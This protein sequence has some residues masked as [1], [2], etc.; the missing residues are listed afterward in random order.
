MA[1]DHFP[2]DDEN[3]QDSHAASVGERQEGGDPRFKSGSREVSSPAS[4]APLPHV[5]PSIGRVISAVAV[6]FVLIVGAYFFRHTHQGVSEA[7]LEQLTREFPPAIARVLAEKRQ[8]SHLNKL[9]ITKKE[10]DPAG[11]VHFTY[12]LSFDETTPA[13]ESTTNTLNQ[14]AVLKRNGNTWSVT[15]IDPQSQELSFHTELAIESEV[16]SP[17]GRDHAPAA[18]PASDK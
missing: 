6:I 7:E 18:A 12:L 10:V 13:G 17:S 5:G 11:D 2:G 1:Q 8:G 15:T 14:V 9:E 4:E 3:D 16:P